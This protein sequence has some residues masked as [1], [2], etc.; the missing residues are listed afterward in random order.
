MK[1]VSRDKAGLILARIAIL[2][3]S[4]RLTLYLV[5]NEA[6]VGTAIDFTMTLFVLILAL[7]YEIQNWDNSEK[8]RKPTRKKSETKKLQRK[9]KA[10]IYGPL[11]FQYKSFYKIS[12]ATQKKAIIDHNKY[13]RNFVRKHKRNPN[14]FELGRIV[15]GFSHKTIPQRGKRGHWKR[16][17]LRQYIYSLHKVSYHKK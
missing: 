5:P 2:F 10:K 15:R 13:L 17:W 12:I 9:G 7:W 6:F 4:I 11:Q 16:Q 8:A 3:T 1:E 14:R